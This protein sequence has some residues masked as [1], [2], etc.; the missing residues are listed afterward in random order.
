MN[1]HEATGEMLGTPSKE[2]KTGVS[3]R[4]FFN[5]VAGGALG[6]AGLG[7]YLSWRAIA[8]NPMSETA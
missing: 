5:E 6:V 1:Q 7:L 4:D 8:G 2:E 3:R